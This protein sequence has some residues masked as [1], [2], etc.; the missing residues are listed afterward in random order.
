V[1][2][3]FGTFEQVGVEHPTETMPAIFLRDNEAVDID[4]LVKTRLKPLQV[5]AVIDV[6]VLERQ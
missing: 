6:A 1:T 2:K 5:P 4:E 3:P